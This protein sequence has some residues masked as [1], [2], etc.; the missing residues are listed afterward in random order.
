[1]PT[2]HDTS[3]AKPAIKQKPR[4]S[5]IAQRIKHLQASETKTLLGREF[6]VSILPP[7]PDSI[8]P[9]IPMKTKAGAQGTTVHPLVSSPEILREVNEHISTKTVRDI[10][11]KPA[12]QGS[13]PKP[14]SAGQ[15]ENYLP[16]GLTVGMIV[17][18]NDGKSYKLLPLPPAL[19]KA[20]PVP[21]PPQVDLSRWMN[22]DGK[23]IFSV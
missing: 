22:E 12:Q 17:K 21:A 7:N 14:V 9:N 1:M 4:E 15:K 16:E 10:T 19:G 20:P 3:V 11:S 23:I 13:K 8:R 6:I 5:L 2:D 18:G